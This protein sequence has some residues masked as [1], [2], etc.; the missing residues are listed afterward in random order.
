M[1]RPLFFDFPE[2]QSAWYP[3]DEYLFGDDLLVAPI[4]EDDE[5]SRNVYLPGGGKWMDYHSRA[6]YEGGTW[7]RLKT[8]HYIVV[9]VREGSLIPVTEPGESVEKMSW[10]SCRLAVY[11][12]DNPYLSGTVPLGKTEI[13]KIRLP[14]ADLRDYALSPDALELLRK[15]PEK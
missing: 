4:F 10:E 7:H 15:P 11:R 9:L 5:N 13:E 8:D 12:R 6:C 14:V 3:E 1:I 2:D